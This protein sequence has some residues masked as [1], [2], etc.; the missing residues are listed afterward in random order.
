MV[1]IGM[2]I[3]DRYEIIEKIGTGG[4]SD[5]YKALDTKLNRNVA[6][7]VLK[8]EFGENEN[9]VSK[10]RV[11][12]QAA[13][14]L[15][16]S[17]IVNV[18][19]VGEEND[20]HYIV[21]ELV[22][23]IT[24]KK[25]IEKKARLTYK[26]AVSIA[27]QVSLGIESAHANHIIHRDI[28]PQNIIISRDGKVKVTDFGIAKA[29]TSN[30][31]T[32]NVMGSVHYTSPEQARGGYSDEKSDIYSLG[33]SMFEM[34]TGRVPFN[35]E[36]TVAIAIKHIQ[37]PMPSPR[38]YVPE[39]PQ[40]VE[41]IIFKCCEKSPDRRYQNM[42]ELIA[43]LKQ[44]LLTPDVDFVVRDEHDIAGGTRIVSDAEV[45]KIKN[46]STGRVSVT[47]DNLMKL[48]PGFT[49]DNRDPVDSREEMPE[50]GN[51]SYDQYYG[52]NSGNYNDG[53]EG[54]YEGGYDGEYAD[55]N[56]EQSEG[57]YDSS[58]ENYDPAYDG[59]NY[60]ENYGSDNYDNYSN[61]D[62]G[63]GLENEDD[64]SPR[65]ERV[66]TIIAIVA[67][68]IIVGIIAVLAITII[69]KMN[70]A[71]PIPGT[72]EETES[73]V[74]VGDGETEQTPLVTEI[75]SLP[76]MA[77]VDVDTVKN[78]LFALGV[79]ANFEYEESDSVEAGT[80]ISATDAGGKALSEGSEVP[81]GSSIN[82]KVSSGLAGIEVPAV[83]NST[84][85][86]AANALTR[87]GFKVSKVEEY[88]DEV[89]EGFVISV[90]PESGQ[91]VPKGSSIQIIVSRGPE[92][93]TVKVP[94]L[95]GLTT[96]EALARI[97]ENGLVVGETTSVNSDSIESGKICQQ[98]VEAGDYVEKG[99]TVNIAISL[100]VSAVSYRFEAYISAPS[101]EEA[102]DYTTGMEV[103]IVLK[104]ANGKV[105]IET[106]E[107]NFPYSG[108]TYFGLATSTG[109]ITMS[110]TVNKEAVVENGV[111]VSPAGSEGK[112]FTRNVEFIQE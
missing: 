86:S 39:I 104:D 62:R 33:I 48:A 35:G 85:E 10:F 40:C 59:G 11:E 14:G 72:G 16:H 9:F 98:S 53:Y 54:G 12:A 67:G 68:V 95:I 1:K 55:G 26:E 37:E 52:D 27:I 105:I 58:E 36:T 51:A 75:V 103:T 89:A 15:M 5:V 63:S 112:S 64:Y 109:T 108:G 76:A 3:N 44:A 13:A 94:D 57:S 41:S 42:A 23:G 43:D 19:D 25:Y 77:G 45:A 18:Y 31:I 81:K 34:L 70:S 66:T 69:S 83:K 99:T 90:N 74:V 110:Y 30:T 20:I 101:V 47:D 28:K 17:N 49:S 7:K 80:V 111:E 102:P 73:H 24:L 61:Y 96:D 65:M 46:S 38:E 71:S 82:I 32:S 106:K 107:T 91:V 97:V 29:A 21:M 88:S 6:I 100:G 92:D 56:Y 93:T 87:E 78:E 22:E 2:V 4:M 84:Y 60:E 50:D 79:S 8:A